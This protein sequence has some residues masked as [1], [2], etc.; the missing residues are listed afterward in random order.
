MMELQLSM[1]SWEGYLGLT[2]LQIKVRI[3]SAKMR[4]ETEHWGKQ[5]HNRSLSKSSG[6]CERVIKPFILNHQIPLSSV[7]WPLKWQRSHTEFYCYSLCFSIWPKWIVFQTQEIETD[8]ILKNS[9]RPCICLYLW[10]VTPRGKQCRSSQRQWHLSDNDH[11]GWEPAIMA[12]AEQ[13]SHIYSQ[14]ENWESYA[15]LHIAEDKLSHHAHRQRQRESW[16]PWLWF[17]HL[18]AF[19]LKGKLNPCE[20]AGTDKPSAKAAG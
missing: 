9:F 20:A 16:T 13:R 3:S 6:I 5:S 7:L 17:E 10:R 8:I 15:L 12:L 2:V 18:A 4:W 1:L 11:G 14:S 19:S